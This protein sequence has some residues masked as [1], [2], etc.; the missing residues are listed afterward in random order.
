M[1]KRKRFH[2]YFV[3]DCNC[4]SRLKGYANYLELTKGWARNVLKSVEW[5][6][7]NEKWYGC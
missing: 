4:S 3:Q 6:K 1:L 2:K 5:S 7:R